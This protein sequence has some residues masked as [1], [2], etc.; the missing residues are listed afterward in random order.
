MGAWRTPEGVG[1]VKEEARLKRSIRKSSCSVTCVCLLI[2]CVICPVEAVS[3][4]DSDTHYFVKNQVYQALQ[5]LLEDLRYAR[6]VIAPSAAASSDFIL[7]ENGTGEIV[8]YFS[9]SRGDIGTCERVV[10]SPDG[11]VRSRSV[12]LAGVNK[13]DFTASKEIWSGQGPEK[14]DVSLSVE[15]T[16]GGAKEQFETLE[17]STGVYLVNVSRE[18][19]F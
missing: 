12:W 16:T 11:T 18:W 14:I 7:F 5:T 2:L 6:H 17:L 4:A 8:G 13:L 15:F 3:S 9:S 1:P 19:M 10:V